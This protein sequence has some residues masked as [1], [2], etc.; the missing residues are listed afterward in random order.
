M[1][2]ME[3][4]VKYDNNHMISTVYCES[5]NSMIEFTDILDA[6]NVPYVI[7]NLKKYDKFTLHCLTD[8]NDM[9]GMGD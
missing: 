4:L 6:N 9:F 8:F 2:K 7:V 5:K 3:Y 1:K